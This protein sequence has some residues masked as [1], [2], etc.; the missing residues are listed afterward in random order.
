MSHDFF[1]NFH[2]LDPKVLPTCISSMHASACLSPSPVNIP[3]P[4]PKFISLPREHTITSAKIQWCEFDYNTHCPQFLKS[5]SCHFF[6]FSRSV[7]SFYFWFPPYVSLNRCISFRRY[8]QLAVPLDTL[9]RKGKSQRLLYY[10][11]ITPLDRGFFLRK[12]DCDIW[13]G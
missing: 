11:S 6:F 7:V 13:E 10:P 12:L 3:L 8:E 2:P 5:V 1:N 9:L 4:V